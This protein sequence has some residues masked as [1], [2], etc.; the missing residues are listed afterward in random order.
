MGILK[1]I[2]DK[3]QQWRVEGMR[4]SQMS[5]SGASYSAKV[6]HKGAG[7]YCNTCDKH[8]SE[9]DYLN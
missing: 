2:K 3:W 7:D 8:Y 1:K 9:C 5:E 6:E 4:I